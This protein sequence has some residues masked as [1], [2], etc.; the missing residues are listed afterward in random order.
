MISDL[1]NYQM[2]RNLEDML[3]SETVNK[4]TMSE[5]VS[6]RLAGVVFVL[7]C[8]SLKKAVCCGRSNYLLHNDL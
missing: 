1:E 8:F 6:L 3:T 5:I 4:L 2:I 7:F